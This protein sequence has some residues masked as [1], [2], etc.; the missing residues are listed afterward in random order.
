[1]SV[2]QKMYRGQTRFDFIAIS[3]TTLKVSLALVLLSLLLMVVRPFNL[4]IDFTGGVLVTVD[5][6][7][8][9]TVEEVRADLREVGF[10]RCARSDHGR[11]R[12]CD[13]SRYRP[14]SLEPDAQDSLV[15]AVS[16]AAGADVNDVNVSCGWSRPLVPR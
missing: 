1:M 9:A 14:K 4:S 12:G 11:G 7:A 3:R 16:S 10:R 13:S 5:N 6:Q 8:N 15:S 2:F